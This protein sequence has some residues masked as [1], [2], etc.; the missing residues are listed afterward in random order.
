[1]TFSQVAIS[2]IAAQE[3]RT[4]AV[5]AGVNVP[6][7][8]TW[9]WA[10]FEET[11]PDRH[12][13]GFFSVEVDGTPA[14]IFSLTRYRYHGF[15]FLW[16]KHGPVW[17]VEQSEELENATVKAMVK[18]IKKSARGTAF[19]RLHLR[20]PGPDVQTPMQITTYDRTVLVTLEDNE[21]DLMAGFKK[22]G[23]SRIRTALKR[24]PVSCTDETESAT[25]DFTPYFD[26]MEETAARQGFTSWPKSVYR[27]MLG[28]LKSEHSR[29]YAA[30][31]EGKLVAFAIFTLSGTEAV[32]YYA[33]ANEEGR[34]HEASVQV[35]YY[36]CLE[37]GAEGL[38]TMD[39]MGVGSDLAP[40]LHSLTPLKSCF[41]REISEV[42]PA[43][44][45]PVNH[46]AFATLEALKAA[47]SKLN[48]L[49]RKIS[50]REKAD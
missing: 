30:R 48:T 31:I 33:A 45:V 7:E 28:T 23:R 5:D 13:V 10:E 43:Y 12:L 19:L 42:D 16:C 3:M 14:A 24:T 15:D 27:N 9:V 47:K 20:F 40:S 49:R 50:E 25:E 44:D 46:A 17:L 36:A 18:W 38:K 11:F 8:Q 4:R 1:M 32:Y 37:L 34:D 39:L 21:S 26:I 22:R 6:I 35:L 29:L 2:P 41:A